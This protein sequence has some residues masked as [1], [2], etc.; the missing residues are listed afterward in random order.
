MSRRRTPT[1]I[2]SK[3]AEAVNVFTTTKPGSFN[4]RPK[5]SYEPHKGVIRILEEG[6]LE[7]TRNFFTAFNDSV[8]QHTGFVI[9]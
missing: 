3:R 6:A 5:E 7:R 4:P 8:Q 1:S 9:D 2:E